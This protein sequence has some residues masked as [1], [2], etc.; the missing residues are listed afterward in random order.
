MANAETFG[1]ED[2]IGFHT[3]MA[4]VPALRMSERLPDAEKA[5]PVL[6]VIYWNAGRIQEIGGASKKTLH[7]IVAKAAKTK[8]PHGGESLRA[9]SREDD[10]DKAENLF[11]GMTKSSLQDA[12]NHLQWIVQDDMNVHRFVLAHRVWKLVDIVG[13]A[14][15][16]TI[17]RQSVR[18]CVK[19][20]QNIITNEKRHP[21]PIRTLV[22][23]LLD[24]HNLIGRA[25]GTKDPED[26]WVEEL[27]TLIYT[28]GKERATDAVAAAIAEGFSPE[29]IGE[30]ISLA[31]NQL[32]LRQ[33]NGRTHGDSRGVHGSDAMNAWRNM[34]RVTNP[35]NT[36]V[37]L[38]VGAYHTAE[39]SADPKVKGEPYPHEAHRKMV[40]ATGPDTLLK[41]AEGAIR[42][43]L[44]ERH[45]NGPIFRKLKPGVP[46]V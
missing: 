44:A 24:Q 36:V 39:Y 14:H 33:G 20:E 11:A 10:M 5:L 37:G 18:F 35:R 6:K 45:E 16:H 30:A 25:L 46:S 2:Y 9:I 7:P 12:Y 19:N 38:L 42:E 3:E 15:A 23:K 13:P 26:T 32:V 28:A 22:P 17:P 29:S 8:D 41:E 21:S 43:N 1:G 31:A 34:N 40:K 4:L 27:S